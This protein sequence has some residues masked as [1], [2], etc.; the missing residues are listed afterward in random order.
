MRLFT[1]LWP[2]RE[3]V[4]DLSGALDRLPAAE[5]RAASAGLRGFGFVPSERWHLTLCFHGDGADPDQL[6]DRLERRV[7][8]AA[9]EPPRM[10]LAGSGTF[11]S[12][13]WLGAEPAADRDERALRELVRAAGGEPDEHL[14]HVTVA[15]WRRGRA[16]SGLA[17]LLGDYAGP[18]WDV[19]EVVLVRSDQRAGGPA[20][21]TVRR[22]PLGGAASGEGG[23]QVFS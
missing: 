12:V 2:S 14:A 17:R 4:R 5:V 13:L 1:G 6:G 15:R 10:R 21:A 8:E 11:A 3:A 19:G 22:V 20:Y 16:R 18:W 9:P 23:E 7:R